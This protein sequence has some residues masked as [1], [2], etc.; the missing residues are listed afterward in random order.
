MKI[1]ANQEMMRTVTDRFATP[2]LAL[3]ILG[4]NAFG[5]TAREVARKSFPSVV[6]IEMQDGA[7]YPMAFGSGFFVED[8]VVASNFH[9]VEGASKGTIKMSG[10]TE[11]VVIKSILASDQTNDLIFLK[12]PRGD[13]PPLKLAGSSS[14]EVGDEVFAVGSPHGL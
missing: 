9:V 3:L 8:E 5:Q 4:T 14:V 12:V 11:K 6:S 7:G 13:G 2:A 1:M 10:N